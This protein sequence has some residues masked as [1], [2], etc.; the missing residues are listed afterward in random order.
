M[1]TNTTLSRI[2]LPWKILESLKEYEPNTKK[3]RFNCLLQNELLTG[4]FG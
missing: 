4:T 2:H 3:M 1:I